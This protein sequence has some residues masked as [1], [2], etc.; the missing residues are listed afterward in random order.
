VEG[1][2]VAANLN[3]KEGAGGCRWLLWSVEQVIS[4]VWHA[5]LLADVGTVAVGRT[6]FAAFGVEALDGRGAREHAAAFVAYDVD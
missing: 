1:E 4:G 3:S 5:D 6:R 2:P